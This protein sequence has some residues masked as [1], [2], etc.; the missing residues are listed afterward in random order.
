M[1][2]YLT[3]VLIVN[4]YEK[5]SYSNDFVHELIKV[6]DYIS[7]QIFFKISDPQVTMLDINSFS[8]D[9]RNDTY[10]KIFSI[11]SKIKN[12]LF[13]F[14]SGD[15]DKATELMREVFGVNFD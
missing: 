1:P 9:E 6:L 7:V 13:Y 5:F 2:S 8:I 10:H 14:N 12:A 15:N 3:E 4:Y 11:S